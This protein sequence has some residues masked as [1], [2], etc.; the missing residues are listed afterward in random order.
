[1]RSKD[2]KT[3]GGAEG[4]WA[5]AWRPKPS[6]VIGLIM[7]RPC[8]TRPF[9]VGLQGLGLDLPWLGVDPWG[10][11]GALQQAVG[12]LVANYLPGGGIP[13]QAAA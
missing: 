1:M 3:V 6:E 13:G 4:H 11:V 12:F 2:R 5:G 9:R 10:A 7:S 8:S